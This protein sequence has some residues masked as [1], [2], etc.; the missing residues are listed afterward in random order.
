MDGG[1]TKD[2]R[3]WVSDKL[4]YESLAQVS[5]KVE[6]GWGGSGIDVNQELIDVIKKCEKNQVRGAR[7]RGWKGV[8]SGSGLWCEPN[9]K[10][11]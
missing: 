2:A 9:I 1:T 4:T 6:W 5:L 10:L 11:F 3:P 8:R 7:R